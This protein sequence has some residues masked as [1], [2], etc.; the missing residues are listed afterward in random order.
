MGNVDDKY[1]LS[2]NTTGSEFLKEFGDRKKSL[3][4]LKVTFLLYELTLM[5]LSYKVLKIN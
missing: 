3:K 2:R 4:N 1:K 5:D